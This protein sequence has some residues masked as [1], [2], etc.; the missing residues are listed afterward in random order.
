M[1]RPDR[2]TYIDR[3]LA[4]RYSRARTEV[5]FTMT[6]SKMQCLRRS[7][8]AAQNSDA[9]AAT[10]MISALETELG[11]VTTYERVVRWFAASPGTD[12]S[13]R[14]ELNAALA[15]PRDDW[16]W[17][18]Q[19][20]RCRLRTLAEDR[21]AHVERSAD[22]SIVSVWGDHSRGFERAVAAAVLAAA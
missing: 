20:R 15:L 17:G 22:G 16:F 14:A 18:P 8:A 21:I 19:P 11:G 10:E 7:V 5:P 4:G 3:R 9:E 6:T 12:D 2:C 1:V 13:F